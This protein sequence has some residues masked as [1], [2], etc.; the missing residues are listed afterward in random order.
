M[1]NNNMEGREGIITTTWRGGVY[2]NNM[3]RK[4]VYNNNMEMGERVCITTT[5]TQTI[6][7]K[8]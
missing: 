1:Y 7:I 6:V 3:E 2:Y 5:I 8:I 4:S